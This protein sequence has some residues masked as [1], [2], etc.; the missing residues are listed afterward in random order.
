MLIR[1]NFSNYKSFKDQTTLDLSATKENELSF[2]VKEMGGEKILPFAIIYGANASGKTNVQEAFSSM[3]FYVLRSFDVDEKNVE[4]SPFRPIPFL[5]DD[6]AKDKPTSFEVFFILPND[7]KEVVYQYGFSLDKD[8]VVEE[9]LNQKA[10]TARKF[11]KVFYRNRV[12]ATLELEGLPAKVRENL[13]LALRERTLLLSLGE[14]LNVEK[15][16]RVYSFFSFSRV[17][18]NGK[19]MEEGSWSNFLPQHFYDDEQVRKNVLR[20]FAS[21]DES[22]VDFKVEPLRNE[23]NPY[24]KRF[25]IKTGHRKVGKDEITYIP[26]AMES[27]GTLKMF[28]LYS[29]VCDVMSEGG[30]MFVDE[31]NAKL[32]PLLVRCFVSMFLDAEINKFGAQLLFTSHDSWQLNNG[33]FRRDEIWMSEKDSSGVS[34]LY[35]LSDFSGNDGRALVRSDENFEKNYLLG[36]YG[37]IPHM[38]Q[39]QIDTKEPRLDEK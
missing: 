14:K 7:E 5:F 16:H 8:G 34:S 37:A 15:L 18:G 32:H 10:R 11:A 4:A 29:M 33:T 1:F 9:W 2:H 21:F 24:E 39:F 35:S 26:L 31:L 12:D 28:S 25:A 22:I 38:K 23:N 36:K 3:R 27:G 30:V 19:L 6:K 13:R 17:A 20:Y